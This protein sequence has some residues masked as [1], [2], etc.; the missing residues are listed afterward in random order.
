MGAE[1]SGGLTPVTIPANGD[2]TFTLSPVPCQR[3]LVRHRDDSGDFLLSGQVPGR[4]TCGCSCNQ[5]AQYLVDFG[6]N[7][8]IPEGGTVEPI[9]VALTL[10]GSP[11]QTSAMIVTPAAVEQYQNI[12]R[13]IHVPVWCDCGCATLTVRNISAQPILAQFYNIVINYAGVTRG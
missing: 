5:S 11:V 12:S 2:F 7:V 3:G 13:A 10:N 4:C 6:A 1:Y 8:A 9:S